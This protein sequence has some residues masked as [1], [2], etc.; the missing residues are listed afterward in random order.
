[1]K[2]QNKHVV[3][4]KVIVTKDLFVC[5]LFNSETSGERMFVIRPDSDDV[6]DTIKSIISSFS[7]KGFL[8]CGY[9]NSH[10][11]NALI[12]YIFAMKNDWC[13]YAN[14]KEVLSCI[15]NMNEI[16]LNEDFEQWKL[17]K[18]GRNFKSFDLMTMHFS[19]KERISLQE[20][21]F[22]LNLDHIS[23]FSTSK[24]A[25]DLIYD[26]QSDLD[27]IYKLLE[28]SK[29]LIDV[30]LD[31]NNEY[32]IGT[33]SLDSVSLGKKIFEK[34]Y[35]E[36]IKKPL[37]KEKP[38]RMIHVADILFPFI[39]FNDNTLKDVLKDVRLLDIDTENP[40]LEKTFAYHGSKLNFCLGGLHSVQC[41]DEFIMNSDEV[42]VSIDAE[43][44]FPTIVTKYNAYP[45]RLGERFLETY[46]KILRERLE[47][48]YSDKIKKSD[49]LKRLLVS[50][51]GMFNNPNDTFYDPKSYYKVTI[52]SQFILLMLAESIVSKLDCKIINWNTDGLFIVMKRIDSNK[53][54][55]AVD[56]FKKKFGFSFKLEAYKKMYQTDCNNYFA[57]KDEYD[58]KT[59]QDGLDIDKYITC[60]GIFDYK[61][62]IGKAKNAV[63]IPKSVIYKCVLGK[64]IKE[65]VKGCKNK[66]MF[67]L[68]SKMD[69]QSKA[70]FNNIPIGH[71]N[72]YYYS[73]S[74][75]YLNKGQ[76]VNNSIDITPVTNT[77]YC[78]KLFND[79]SDITD[80]NY[81]YY[82]GQAN[83]LLHKFHDNQ[84]KL[85]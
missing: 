53:L 4:F 12:N 66:M 41:P 62:K 1:M 22:S 78:I 75:G 23:S 82:I 21:K 7:Y 36:N 54:F 38:D 17:Y 79:I 34:M 70:Y 81:N 40:S 74:G 25:H 67:M 16:I 68:F 28:C 72:R 43:S 85:F 6:Q 13:E 59:V 19:K 55:S 73:V 46:K 15:F 48:K 2:I 69:S 5:K 61:Y 26:I 18:Y 32:N 77:K 37:E 39:D 42:I 29:E 57:V 65:S 50:I 35:Y 31:F 80:I 49:I 60:K 11:D 56:E 71:I 3:C 27:A 45:F 84:L 47:L 24:S 44:M 10:Y 64:P 83:I 33:L 9:N 76:I 58:I 20:L 30:R 63:I 8:F 52:N 51:V 14:P